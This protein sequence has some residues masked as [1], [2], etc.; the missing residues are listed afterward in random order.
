M[1]LNKY[2]AKN[3]DKEHCKGTGIISSTERSGLAA[4]G[5]SESWRE[6]KPRVIMIQQY[7]GLCVLI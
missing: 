2:W 1:D 7:E 6:Q 5:I 4:G 3:G